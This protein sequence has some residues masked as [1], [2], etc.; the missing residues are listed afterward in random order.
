MST[1]E[2][3]SC[4][5]FFQLLIAATAFALCY[6]ISS[7]STA[8]GAWSLQ[9][10]CCKS[11]HCSSVLRSRGHDKCH[12]DMVRQWGNEGSEWYGKGLREQIHKSVTQQWAAGLWLMYGWHLMGSSTLSQRQGGQ[13]Q[14][15]RAFQWDTDDSFG[16]RHVWRSM[17]SNWSRWAG[18]KGQ[19]VGVFWLAAP[20][21]AGNQMLA[22][23]LQQQLSEGKLWW[24][25]YSL[26]RTSRKI[27]FE[28]GT[29]KFNL[30]EHDLNV[31][32]IC[33]VSACRSL[34][35]SQLYFGRIDAS[36]VVIHHVVHET[37]TT[38]RNCELTLSFHHIRSS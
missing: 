11:Q 25:A 15:Q 18:G 7:H 21:L 14:S 22:W 3:A 30:F 31:T 34:K 33:C 32:P 20:G 35:K 24:P 19:L 2:R 4:L 8:V 26:E 10:C 9:R 23:K 37:L 6:L 16:V 1:A 13:E 29:R 17:K 38:T 27:V 36:H 5:I 28:R 12:H